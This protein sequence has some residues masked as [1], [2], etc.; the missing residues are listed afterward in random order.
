LRLLLLG[1]FGGE[2]FESFGSNGYVVN[3]L[4][5][6]RVLPDCLRLLD[7]GIDPSLGRVH[8]FF[9]FGPA[10]LC[11]LAGAGFPVVGARV[12]RVGLTASSSERDCGS[13]LW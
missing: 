8:S 1:F 10:S 2:L 6:L 12:F 5:Q 9:G 11:R 13:V 3:K 4:P 7:G